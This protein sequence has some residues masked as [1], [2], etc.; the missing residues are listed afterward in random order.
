MKR[1][2]SLATNV[3]VLGEEAEKVRPNFRLSLN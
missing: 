1:N 3:R 2:R